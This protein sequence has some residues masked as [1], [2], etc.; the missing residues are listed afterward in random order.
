MANLS[1][2]LR[3]IRDSL[4][5]MCQL[6]KIASNRLDIDY[7]YSNGQRPRG[8]VCHAC[9]HYVLKAAE[10]RPQL[11]QQCVLDYLANPPLRDI[12]PPAKQPD[13]RNCYFGNFATG[14]T[15]CTRELFAGRHLHSKLR[16]FDMA[17][18]DTKLR[19]EVEYIKPA[20]TEIFEFDPMSTDQDMIRV[21][22][23]AR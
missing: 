2:Q 7:D 11:V 14:S 20:H 6:C 17:P 23:D 3:K 8:I 5:G 19:V 15:F 18:D 1:K 4:E 9:N 10:C 12:K 21:I 13:I 16:I 22:L